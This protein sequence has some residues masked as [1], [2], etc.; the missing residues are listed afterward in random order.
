MRLLASES[1]GASAASFYFMVSDRAI[2][3]HGSLRKEH[4]E[5][6]QPSGDPYYRPIDRARLLASLPAH[7]L[8]E[9]FDSA[10]AKLTG[11]YAIILFGPRQGLVCEA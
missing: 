10:G 4:D 6:Q 1:N 3:E 2:W 8:D 7:L 11:R 9:A 5:E